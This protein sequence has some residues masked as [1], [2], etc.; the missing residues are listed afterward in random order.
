MS[1]LLFIILIIVI[2]TASNNNKNTQNNNAK[3]QTPTYSNP[4]YNQYYFS[5]RSI[6]KLKFYSKK[7][8]LELFGY[9][10]TNSLFYTSTSKSD[11]PFAIYTKS[12]PNFGETPSEGLNY[13]P[14]YNQIS[15][16][17]GLLV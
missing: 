5:R 2:V 6:P 13:W 7:D 4:T 3:Y 17:Q 15:K 9:T 8:T 10:I 12:T 11:M 1:F 16:T 14:N